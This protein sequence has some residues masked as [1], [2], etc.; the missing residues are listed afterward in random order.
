MC[1]KIFLQ[2]LEH[3]FA[4]CISKVKMTRNRGVSFHLCTL[5]SQSRNPYFFLFIY[6]LITLLGLVTIRLQICKKKQKQIDPCLTDRGDQ[7][8]LQ[9]CKLVKNQLNTH[10]VPNNFHCCFHDYIS[11][12]SCNF[13]SGGISK[14]GSRDKGIQVCSNST[15]SGVQ[16]T[17]EM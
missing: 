12:T 9:K 14:D 10:Q 4:A 15:N 16:A 7:Q 8:H 3:E 17:V 2:S 13:D 11:T 1:G 6:F 5:R